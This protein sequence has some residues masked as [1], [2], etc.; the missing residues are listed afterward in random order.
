LLVPRQIV[1]RAW[2]PE[3]AAL[4]TRKTPVLI[5]VPEIQVEEMHLALPPGYQLAGLPPATQLQQP[6]GSFQAGVGMNG[7]T[8]TIESRLE[9]THSLIAPSGY[10]AFRTFWTQVDATQGR[11]LT[12]H[13]SA[14]AAGGAQ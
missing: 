8:L 9:T 4:G 12:A 1:P 3:M 14:A 7:G 2:L 13:A 6:F 10:A 11:A 5:G